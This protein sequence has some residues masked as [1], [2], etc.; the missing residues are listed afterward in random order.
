MIEPTQPGVSFGRKLKY[1]AGRALFGDIPIAALN[2][3]WDTKTPVGTVV[4]NAYT[5][6]AKMIVVETGATK[7]GSARVAW[8]AAGGRPR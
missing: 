2:Y 6:F 3:I 1:K 8:H 4:D 5:D 7:V